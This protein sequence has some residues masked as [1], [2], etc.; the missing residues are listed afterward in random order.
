MR[1]L[2][3][4]SEAISADAL[5][6]AVGAD[7]ADT[8]EVLVVAPALNS[9]WRFFLADPDPAIERAE[10]IE[11]ESVE[12]L[13]GEGIDAAGEPGDADPPPA[14]QHALVPHP[15]DELLL[16]PHPAGQPHWRRKGG[17]DA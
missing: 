6:S 16:L 2:A 5:R 1:I 9:S 14:L 10:R 15:P 3:L 7:T 13:D 8:A 4:T 11:E 12:R 17:P